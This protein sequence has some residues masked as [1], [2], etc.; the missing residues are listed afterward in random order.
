MSVRIATDDLVANV[1]GCAFACHDFSY[2]SGNIK[3]LGLSNLLAI[4]Y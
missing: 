1:G 4:N 2:L 3:K